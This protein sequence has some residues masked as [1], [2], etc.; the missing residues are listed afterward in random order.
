M[1]MK[2]II[3]FVFCAPIGVFAQ[4]VTPELVSSSGGG[5]AILQ[6]SLGEPVIITVESNDNV[7]TQGFHQTLLTITSL[8]ELTQEE[9]AINIYPNPVMSSFSIN[10]NQSPKEPVS[11]KLFDMNGKVVMMDKMNAASGSY[12]VAHLSS[13]VYLLQM[14]VS[15]KASK[16][17]RIVKQ[18]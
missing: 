16:S 10:L 11:W 5:N 13:G 18:N 12:N 8:D 2:R 7:L 15:D 3:I 14:D 17:W 9:I 4:S 1:I 6:W